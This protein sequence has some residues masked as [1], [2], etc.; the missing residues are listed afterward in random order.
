MPG[1]V[2][3]QVVDNVLLV[4]RPF[5][6]RNAA[7]QDAY[8]ARFLQETGAGENAHFIDCWDWYHLYNGESHC[9]TNA[10]RTCPPGWEWWANW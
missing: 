8:R 4:P 9:G 3:L 2:N 5:G 1:M 6:P 7:G 10:N